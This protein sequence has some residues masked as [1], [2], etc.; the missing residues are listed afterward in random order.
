[1]DWY[2]LAHSHTTRLRHFAADLSLPSTFLNIR[3]H[4]ALRAPVIHPSNIRTVYVQTKSSCRNEQPQ[5]AI[6]S[7][8]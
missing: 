3:V 2:R 8:E 7:T 6:H 1:M 5:F 4:I